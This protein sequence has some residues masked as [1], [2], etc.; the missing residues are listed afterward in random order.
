M[1]GGY[2]PPAVYDPSRRQGRRASVARWAERQ[3]PFS[4]DDVMNAH[5]VTRKNAQKILSRLVADGLLV[6]CGSYEYR[7]VTR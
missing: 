4:V 3:D 5:S 2:T 6:R 7:A 1:S